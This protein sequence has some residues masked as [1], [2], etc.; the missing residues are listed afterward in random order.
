MEKKVVRKYFRLQLFFQ[1]LC[2]IK[3]GSLDSTQDA[4]SNFYAFPM[5]SKLPA[6]SKTRLGPLK[7]ES[8]VIDDI[9]GLNYIF[10]ISNNEIQCCRSSVQ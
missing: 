8:G 4:S 1:S 5:P 9:W 3:L 10:I 6:L 2:I 7:H